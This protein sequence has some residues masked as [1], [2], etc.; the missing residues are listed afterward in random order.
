MAKFTKNNPKVV[1]PTSDNLS[2]II[3][4]NYPKKNYFYSDKPISNG[5]WAPNGLTWRFFP[6]NEEYKK[7]EKAI[8]DSNIKYWTTIYDLPPL[9]R[10][11]KSLFFLD[12]IYEIYANQMSYVV[13]FLFINGKIKEAK[14]ILDKFY[15]SLGDQYLYQASY[16]RYNISEK[17]CNKNTEEIFNKLKDRPL[18]KAFDYDYLLGYIETCQKNNLQLKRQLEKEIINQTNTNSQNK[19]SN[20]ITQP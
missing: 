4:I 5:V 19:D 10:N 18:K 7:F 1:F 11:E 2:K 15:P 9:T 13:N 3:E 20:K 8:I 6:N 14:N 17:I 12:H 16:L